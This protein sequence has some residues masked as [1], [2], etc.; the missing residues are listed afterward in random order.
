M[1]Q[2][3][4]INAIMPAL[5][6]SII[7]TFASIIV[8]SGKDWYTHYKGKKPN[9]DLFFSFLVYMISMGATSLI[10]GVSGYL[11]TI[12]K[13]YRLVTYWCCFLI[14]IFLV[15]VSLLVFNRKAN[16]VKKLI[17]KRKQFGLIFF[18]LQ[19]GFGVIYISATLGEAIYMDHQLGSL[20]GYTS[21]FAL[22]MAV[23]IAI[24]K[25]IN[26]AEDPYSKIKLT[27]LDGE[28]MY[29]SFKPK[30]CKRTNKFIIIFSRDKNGDIFKETEINRDAIKQIE[31]LSKE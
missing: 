26:I 23:I 28:I 25:Q 12:Y 31:Y 9:E 27:M 21:R 7:T 4:I 22:M 18:I 3:E 15:V 16:R 11:F 1:N 14:C 30:D 5:A 20:A 2:E 13:G 19:I 8:Y 6:G 10:I 17:Q 24:K 29:Y